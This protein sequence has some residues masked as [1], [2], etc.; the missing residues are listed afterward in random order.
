MKNTYR[1]L[2]LF[3]GLATSFVFGL[4]PALLKENNP[5]PT[6]SSPIYMTDVNGAVFFGADDGTKATELRKTYKSTGLSASGATSC[7]SPSDQNFGNHLEKSY[8][9]E[10]I[11]NELS[12]AQ[13][14]TIFKN[15]Y[16]KCDCY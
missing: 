8:T 5:G 3:F 4:T 11:T 16:L 2:F 12:S 15:S 14:V 6:D 1:T 9:V 13:G 7:G 10:S